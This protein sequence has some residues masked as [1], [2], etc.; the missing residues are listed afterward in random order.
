[1]QPQTDTNS[2]AEAAVPVTSVPAPTNANNFASAEPAAP[3]ANLVISNHAAL[4]MPPVP[5]AAV[6]NMYTDEEIDLLL[7]W[8]AEKKQTSWMARVSPQL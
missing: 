1:M 3:A 2:P 5:R 7:Q 8:N 4:A 6:R